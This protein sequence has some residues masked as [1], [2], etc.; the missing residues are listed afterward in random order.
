MSLK[1]LVESISFPN[2]DEGLENSLFVF[3]FDLLYQKYGNGNFKSVNEFSQLIKDSTDNADIIGATCIYHYNNKKYYIKAALIK[4]NGE[5]N[6]WSI[7]IYHDDNNQRN[8]IK[9]NK[10]S[11]QIE[12]TNSI[13]IYAN[14]A[15]LNNGPN[16][17]ENLLQQNN[18][19]RDT[20]VIVDPKNPNILFDK[21]LEL[22]TKILDTRNIN[23]QNPIQQSQPT[24]NMPQEIKINSVNTILYGPP[25]T[26]KTYH[27]IELALQ[28]LDIKLND[29]DYK[30][31][32]AVRKAKK[33]KFDSLLINKECES[34]VDKNKQGNKEEGRIMFTTFHQS[35]S[36]E[37]FIEGIKPVVENGN[38]TYKVQDGIFK[39]ICKKAEADNDNKYMLIIDEIN[40]GNVA[41]IF[42]EL[43]TLIEDSKRAGKEDAISVTLPYSTDTFSVPN[44]LYILGTM[45]TA[46][47][48]V[49]ALDA[50]LRRRFDFIEMLPQ[51][52]LLSDN[53]E[54]INLQAV[55]KTIN[56]RIEA[57]LDRNH[58]IGHA[59][60]INCETKNDIAQAFNNKIIPLLQ[61]YFY[62]NYERIAMVL[63]SIFV[64]TVDVTKNFAMNNGEIDLNDKKTY[65]FP[66]R[67]ENNIDKAINELLKN[68][69][70]PANEE[71]AE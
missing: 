61:E 60:L 51:P 31:D 67:D 65:T 42:G 59:Y 40:R 8:P 14:R 28:A 36:Y 62:G 53:V 46:D 47:R 30:D 3:Q 16:G 70:A 10:I 52:H 32:K 44:N 41:A 22:T 45:N 7:S 9:V 11:L 21:L 37:D 23:N 26:G 39:K 34:L 20:E 29:A 50:A 24:P 58:L 19:N 33:K 13:R 1:E 56:D 43:I 2:R 27:T 54:G 4:Q 55:L 25:G 5:L 17:W 12:S 15:Q 63:G 49:E 68:S 38:V 18:W 71:T 64:N 35:M 48:S 6:F 69:N 57:L 66:K